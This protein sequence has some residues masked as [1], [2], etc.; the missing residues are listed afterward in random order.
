MNLKEREQ[1]DVDT[2]YQAWDTGRNRALVNMKSRKFRDQVEDCYLPEK[3]SA[4][5]RELLSYAVSV[6]SD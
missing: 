1:K 4:Q 2:T 3:E 6:L 5:Q